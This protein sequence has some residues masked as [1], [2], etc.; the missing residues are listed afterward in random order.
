LGE[1]LKSEMAR[2]SGSER[3][4]EVAWKAVAKQ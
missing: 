1:L 3:C 2:T 4:I